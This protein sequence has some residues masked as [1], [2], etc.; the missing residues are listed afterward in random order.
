MVDPQLQQVPASG[1]SPLVMA[2]MNGQLDTEKLAQLL[3]IQKDYE[4]NEAEKAFHLALSEFKKNKLV[5]DKDKLVSFTTQKGTT[6]YRHTT[7][8]AALSEI[9]P[10]LGNYG[11][12]LGWETQQEGRRITVKCVLSHALGFSKSTSLSAEPDDSGGKNS[13]QAIGSTV[14]YLERYTAFSLLG[15]A[16]KDQDDDGH[17]A[18]VPKEKITEDQANTIN[19]KITDNGLSMAKFLA[20]LKGAPVKA[21]SIPDINAS[22]YD[23]VIATIDDS[24]KAKAAK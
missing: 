7:L 3:A 23:S 12:S 13:I 9:N 8:G 21:R 4:K 6:E 15:I 14:S 17:G 5:L 20:W 22:E 18:S 24:I 11:L 2:A 19:A 1:L 10:M 16:S